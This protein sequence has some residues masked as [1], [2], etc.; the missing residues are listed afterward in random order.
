MIKIIKTQII[1]YCSSDLFTY[2]S[3]QYKLTIVYFKKLKN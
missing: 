1:K 3:S 2:N